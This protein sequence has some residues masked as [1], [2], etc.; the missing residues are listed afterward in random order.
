VFCSNST[1][2][3]IKFESFAC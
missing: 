2:C 1:T 3:F